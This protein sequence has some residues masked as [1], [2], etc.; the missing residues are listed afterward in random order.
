MLLQPSI[1]ADC[2]V[3]DQRCRESLRT[4]VAE[5]TSGEDGGS[6][7]QGGFENYGRLRPV[8]YV[9]VAFQTGIRRLYVLV[10]SKVWTE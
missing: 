5:T 9:A 8:A 3:V 10:S 6:R 2:V 7:Y 4:E 1:I